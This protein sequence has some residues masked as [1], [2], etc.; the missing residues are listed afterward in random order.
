MFPWVTF[1]L[2][3]FPSDHLIP[4]TILPVL[5]PVEFRLS[6]LP[7]STH[8]LFSHISQSGVPTAMPAHFLTY[9]NGS[10]LSLEK[11]ALETDH[12]SQ[13]ALL[14]GSWFCSSCNHMSNSACD[15]LGT[16]FHSFF[17]GSSHF[18]EAQLLYF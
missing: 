1:L 9:Q 3:V 18:L 12:L 8:F 11:M 6:C 13:A 5:T 14:L 15:S 2:L 17:E 7:L 10:F 16:Q 4:F